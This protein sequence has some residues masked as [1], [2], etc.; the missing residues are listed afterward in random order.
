MR[1]LIFGC[2][3]MASNQIDGIGNLHER[4]LIYQKTSTVMVLVFSDELKSSYT[5][6][7]FY[8]GSFKIAFC[9]RGKKLLSFNEGFISK[10]SLCCTLRLLNNLDLA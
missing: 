6:E 8:N 5:I 4:S 1:H 9:T 7:G 10:M 3:S 2:N